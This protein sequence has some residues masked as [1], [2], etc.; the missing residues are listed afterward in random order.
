MRT[1]RHLYSKLKGGLKKSQYTNFTHTRKG[2]VKLD[3]QTADS[4]TDRASCRNWSCARTLLPLASRWLETLALFFPLML[5]VLRTSVMGWHILQQHILQ[6][7]QQ[8]ILH[9][10]SCCGNRSRCTSCR[11]SYSH[12]SSVSQ[13]LELI[14][15]LHILQPPHTTGTNGTTYITAATHNTVSTRT[16]ATTVY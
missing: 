15:L 13:L 9:N 12:Y 3:S 1:L 7:L 5:T 10:S 11:S 4:Q 16:T 8:P 6:L 2:C 14:K